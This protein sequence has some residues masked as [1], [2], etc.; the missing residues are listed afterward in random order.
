MIFKDQVIL[1]HLREHQ[2]GHF[3]LHVIVQLLKNLKDVLIHVKTL[4]NFLNVCLL[5]Y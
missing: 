5:M 2:M 4:Q 1:H 3:S